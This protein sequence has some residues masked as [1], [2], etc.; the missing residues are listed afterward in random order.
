[1]DIGLPDSYLGLKTWVQTV[2]YFKM[3]LFGVNVNVGE[4][5]KSNKRFITARL[6]VILINW[7]SC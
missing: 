4:F 5:G 2:K 6:V 7:N 1:M 3:A